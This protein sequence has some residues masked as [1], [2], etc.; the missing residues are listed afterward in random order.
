[1]KQGPKTM[2]EFIREYETS[3]GT[4]PALVGA[5]IAHQR[6]HGSALGSLTWCELELGWGAVETIKIVAG[7]LAANGTFNKAQ[8]KKAVETA[9]TLASQ[10][11]LTPK[12][13]PDLSLTE[14]PEGG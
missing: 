13:P 14:L 7:M 12:A 1:M 3:G 4:L 8:M 9:K 6:A 2:G 11:G 5:E 10:Y